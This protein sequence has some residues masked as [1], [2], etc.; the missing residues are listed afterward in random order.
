MALFSEKY[1]GIVRV[2]ET[3]G[4]SKELCGG[5]HVR[6][7]SQIGLFKIVSESSVGA[8]LRRIEGLTGRAALEYFDERDRLLEETARISSAV[9]RSRPRLPHDLWIA[10][11]PPRSVSAIF[12]TRAQRVKL[13]SCSSRWSRSRASRL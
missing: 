10:C 9:P 11:A 13:A 7:T 8:G 2:V 5:T 12:S 6:R 3:A 1:S 4:F